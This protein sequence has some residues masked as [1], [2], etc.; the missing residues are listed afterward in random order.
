MRGL[1]RLSLATL[2][3]GFVIGVGCGDDSTSGNP[4]GSNQG[5]GGVGG[6]ASGG[7]TNAGGGGLAN[8]TDI[9]IEQFKLFVT[10]VTVPEKPYF[11]YRGLVTPSLGTSLPDEMGLEVFDDALTGTVDLGDGIEANYQTCATCFRVYEDLGIDA[12][13]GREFFQVAG[14]IDLGS[15][16]PPFLA[17]TVSGLTLVEVTIAKD[18][19]SIPVPGGACL[20]V[21]TFDFEVKQPPA[22]WACVPEFY[23]D[24]EFCDCICGAADSDCDDAS[25]PVVGCARGQTCAPDG[26]ACEGLPTGWTCAADQYAGGAGNGCDCGCGVFDPDC[27]LAGEAVDGCA[28]SEA[29]NTQGACVPT[30]WTCDPDFVSDGDCD[31]GCG[32]V[33]ADCPDATVGVCDFCA[34]N[35][36]C[37]VDDCPGTIDPANN[38]VCQ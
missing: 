28:P 9:T 1:L 18:F 27:D 22:G 33:D 7:G 26:L 24:G 19:R 13:P 30:A 23:D 38:A 31:C 15:T 25:L 10:D 8:C 12:P 34:N 21:E 35:G 29:C 32:A 14:T 4:S 2:L 11:E 20:R 16:T 37:S 6:G 17:G 36:S 3:T 5:G